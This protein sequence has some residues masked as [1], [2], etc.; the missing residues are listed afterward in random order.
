[1]AKKKLPQEPCLFC[2]KIPP[3][4]HNDKKPPRPRKEKAD[5]TRTA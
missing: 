4:E 2:G 5:G 1:M 3:C